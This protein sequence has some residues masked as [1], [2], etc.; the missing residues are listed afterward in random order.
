MTYNK[1]NDRIINITRRNLSTM[2]VNDME[3]V[4]IV[5]W[6]CDNVMWFHKPEET[7]I[8]AKALKIEE[9]EE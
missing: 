9:V 6:D 2:E 8:L 1:I 3:K 4:R 5:I 7:K